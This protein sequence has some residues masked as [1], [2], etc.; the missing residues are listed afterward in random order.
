MKKIKFTDELCSGDSEIDAQHKK[1]VEV[2]NDLISEVNISIRSEKFADILNDLVEYTEVHF[3]YEEYLLEKYHFEDLEDHKK[4]HDEFLENI[5]EI[6]ESVVEDDYSA[7]K[8]LAHYLYAWITK[9]L[10][11]EDKQ[12]FS[13]FKENANDS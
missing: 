5:A 4:K 12:Y 9:H 7:P 13:L 1:I 10:L 11:E 6:I 3:K 2:L 8:V